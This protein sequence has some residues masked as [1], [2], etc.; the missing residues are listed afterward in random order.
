MLPFPL[1]ANN[2]TSLSNPCVFEVHPIEGID[3]KFVL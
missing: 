2:E 3:S 1:G